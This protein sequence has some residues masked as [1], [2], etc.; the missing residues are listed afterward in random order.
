MSELQWALLILSAVVVVALVVASRR[1]RNA[2]RRAEEPS[3][4]PPGSQLDILLREGQFDE[5]GVGR[6]RRRGGDPE[7]APAPVEAAEAPV[8]D[9]PA[10]AP[11]P[12]PPPQKIVSLL[13]VQPDGTPI[14]GTRIHEALEEQGLVY[15]ERQIY[16]R[17]NDSEAVFSVAGLLK[18]GTL[19][20]AEAERFSAPGLS[21]FMVLPGP[22]SAEAALRDMVATAKGLATTL[23]AQVF[24]SRKKPLDRNALRALADDVEDWARRNG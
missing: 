13:V 22:V 8:A 15:G 16:H 18:P 9:A 12:V 5:F 4:G 11:K 2:E 14:A 17:L 20:P 1:G 7:A 6:K 24:D 21:V 3:A 23:G 10:P 19:D